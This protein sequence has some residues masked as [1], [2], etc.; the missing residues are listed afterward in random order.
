MTTQQARESGAIAI[1]G[2]KYGDHVRVVSI[3]DWSRELCG[4]THVDRSTKLGLI[5]LLGESSIGAGVRRVEALVGADAYR[6]LAREHMLVAQLTETLKVRP[7]ELP[8]RVAGILGRLRET[9][10]EIEQLRAA[11]MQQL[12]GQLA[13]AAEDLHGVAVVTRHLSEPATTDELRTLALDVRSRIRDRPAVVAVTGLSN[14]KPI[15]VAAVDDR[16]TA[17]G[18]KAGDLVRAAS[19]VLKG[20]GGGRADVAQ[21]GGSDPLTVPDALQEITRA[22]EAAV[23]P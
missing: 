23:N 5:K 12:A 21:G 1:F 7:D 17:L 8:D 6:F 4:G 13:G 16:A 19:K 10:K 22:V 15:I 9:E 18:I 2:E 14:D 11:R 20:G 3:G